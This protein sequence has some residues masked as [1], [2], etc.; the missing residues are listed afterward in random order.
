MK[1]NILYLLVLIA[2]Q[3]QAI[4]PACEAQQP[5]ILFGLSH[6]LGPVNNW[7]WIIVGLITLVTLLTFVYSLIHLIKPKEKSPNHIKNK[8][9]TF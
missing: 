4:C 7:D 1:K 5:K 2:T 6:G 8:I 9:L 3:V